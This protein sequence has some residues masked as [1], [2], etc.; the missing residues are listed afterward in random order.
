MGRS[1]TIEQFLAT[2]EHG[3]AFD[4]WEGDA[5]ARAGQ[6]RRTLAR[7][8]R[9]IVAWR[10]PHAPLAV[11]AAPAD[12]AARTE[13]RIAPMLTGLFGPARAAR[14][15]PALAR[16]VEVVDP[17][18]FD[19]GCRDLPLHAQWALA[20]M[21]LDAMGA[22]PLSD[23]AP[24]LD[25]FCV[26][27]RAWVLPRALTAEDP[28]VDVIVHEV[29]HLLHELTPAELLPGTGADA[30]RP[31]VRVPLTQ[32]ETWAYG[33]EIWAWSSRGAPAG[34]TLAARVRQAAS[35]RAHDDAR[36]DAPRLRRVLE[37]AVANPDAGWQHLVRGVDAELFEGALAPR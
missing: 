37:E 31:L 15:S 16:R 21:L 13:A 25:G 36:V 20:N 6:G 4:G 1:E 23:T 3:D 12:V 11:G 24:Q 7:I 22:P 17:A 14:L 5:D 26:Q 29:A 34:P 18:R 9:R 35:G 19:G 30:E 28:R 10:A 32:R 33:C 2:G 8:L 27:G